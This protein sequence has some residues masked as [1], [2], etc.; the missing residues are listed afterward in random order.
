MKKS[1]HIAATTLALVMMTLQLSAH[2]LDLDRVHQIA[3]ELDPY[4]EITDTSYLMAE[5]PSI[6][7]KLAHSSTPLEQLQCAIF[8]HE[9]ALNF[10]NDPGYP[11]YAEKSHQI[12]SV[13]LKN[14]SIE[15]ELIPFVLSYQGS[16]LS[17]M[18]AETRSLKQVKAALKIMDVAV[19]EYG[20]MCFA[21]RF[22]RGSICEN[23]PW[24]MFK[25]KTIREDFS[26]M[27]ELY[28]KDGAFA[29][30]KVMSFTYWAWANAHQ[31]KKH[32][33]QAIEYLE[34]AISLDPEGIA[35]KEKAE[36]L[37]RKLS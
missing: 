31:G 5:L 4:M 33:K 28:E 18:A 1:A 21:A 25:G 2:S 12:T 29:N 35:G 16:S 19:E 3:H 37:L 15:P 10:L 6:N 14:A 26:V 8:F 24:F 22:L 7:K 23:L 17:L 20:N 13:L 9:V 34:T 36:T 32:R 30:E 11:G 27:I